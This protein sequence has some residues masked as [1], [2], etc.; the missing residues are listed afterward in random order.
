M[1]CPASNGEQAK[2][3]CILRYIYVTGRYQ[4]VEPGWRL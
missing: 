4:H 1:I 3:G 2:V